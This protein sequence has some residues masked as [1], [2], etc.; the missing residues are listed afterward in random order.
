MNNTNFL[1]NLPTLRKYGLLKLWV[2]PANTELVELYREHITKHNQAI[3]TDNFPNSGFDIFVPNTTVFSTPNM[4]QMVNHEIK[5]EMVFC[6]R[7][8]M[9]QEPSAYMLYPRSSLSKT[10]LMLANHV[11]IIDS[12][13]RGFLIG[14]FRLLGQEYTV[15]KYTRLMQVCLPTLHPI[16]VVMV[17]ESELTDTTRGSGGFGSTG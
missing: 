12:G 16:Y 11:G 6:D 8:T 13:Y 7:I 10:P 3:T 9:T 15:D 14:A 1:N 2:N 17:N 4:S 5:G